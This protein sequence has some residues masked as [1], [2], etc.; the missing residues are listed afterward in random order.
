MTT[1]G[2]T[3]WS[4]TARDIITSAMRELTVLGIG[5]EPRA[6]ESDEAMR[7]LNAMLK[8]WQGEANLFRNA[9]VEVETTPDVAAVE[10]PADVRD[11]S[12]VRHVLSST[13]ERQLTS[14]NRA[15][16]FSMPN[17]AAEGNPTVFYL[18]RQRDV[19]TLYLWPVPTTAQ[20]LKVDYSRIADTLTDLGETLD[21]P[22]EWHE[23]VILGLAS[24]IGNMFG[25]NRM[26]PAAF[27]DIRGRAEML[28]QRMLD[29]DRPD[30]YVFER[31]DY[32]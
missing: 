1:S 8:T 6:T 22:E 4:L 17:R 16:Y 19:A 20:T 26:D 2:V 28:Y 23:T 25:A 12:A 9:E 11:V 21:I 10:M 14:W 5:R 27:A 15:Q 24:R 31:D 32:C 18:D 13:N 7:R 3:E 30:T 29:R